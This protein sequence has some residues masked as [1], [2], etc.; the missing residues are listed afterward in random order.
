MKVPLFTGT[1][2]LP[3][4]GQVTRYICLNLYNRD[5]MNR[6]KLYCK[7]EVLLTVFLHTWEYSGYY[8]CSTS[9]CSKKSQV[10]PRWTQEGAAVIPGVR[11]R[12]GVGWALRA[13]ETILKRDVDQK[14]EGVE[15]GQRLAR[16]KKPLGDLHA[17]GS[18]T[19]APIP[20][21]PLRLGM[22]WGQPAPGARCSDTDAAAAFCALAFHWTHAVFIF[23]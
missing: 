18:E 17:P 1:L 23:T 16:V 9:A 21:Q 2:L 19:A 5:D 20:S 8:I 3:E 22:H 6:W 7:G 10:F 11:A 14:R 13:K 15:H 4:F 12:A